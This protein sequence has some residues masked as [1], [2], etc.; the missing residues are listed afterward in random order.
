MRTLIIFSL[1]VFQPFTHAD[2]FEV[3]ALDFGTIAV[4]DNSSA[5][6]L[7]I[8]KFGNTTVSSRLLVVSPPM[9]GRFLIDNLAPNTG[10]SIS[11]SHN[12]STMTPLI[13][14][15]EFFTFSLTDY[16]DYLVANVIGNSIE[17][18]KLVES[19][20]LFNKAKG[21]VNKGTD[22][23][24][25]LVADANGEAELLI[26]GTITTSGSGSLNFAQTDYRINYRVIFLY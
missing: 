8:D 5:E 11:M 22:Y 15:Q 26:G 2:I 13:S 6:S 7:T 21:L 20:S 3:Q 18:G 25:Y 14:S 9:P 19:K 10:I 1:L 12:A 23:S 17:N 4:I 16:S 24:D